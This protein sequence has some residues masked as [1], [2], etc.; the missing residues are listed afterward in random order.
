MLV[1]V[2]ES[3]DPGRK[4]L[5][6]S[7]QYFVVAL[8]IFDEDEARTCNA[9]IDRL[10]AELYPGSG[11]EFHFSENSNRVREAFLSTVAQARFHYHVFALNKD[12]GVLYGPGFHRK[13]SLYKFTARLAFEN[14]LPELHQAKVILDK[15]GERRF[16]RELK[17]YLNRQVR[18]SDGDR[19]INTITAKESHRDNL[20]QVA[21]YVAGVCNRLICGRQDGQRLWERF[22]AGKEATRRVWPQK[23]PTPSS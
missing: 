23:K 8:V 21:D 4:I 3:G 13:D 19:P 20:L 5:N 7:S 18:Q 22:L 6:R 9:Q 10:R 2:D 17:Q 14:A 16:Q 12:P 1:F 15:S 11:F